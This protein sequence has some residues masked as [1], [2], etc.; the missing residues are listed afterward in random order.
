MRGG[1]RQDRR[2]LGALL[3]HE[4]TDIALV[5]IGG[6]P[7]FG[8]AALMKT[9]GVG[10]E[11][12]KVGG[13]AR[14]A[15]WNDP[16]GDPDVERYTLAEAKA[17]LTEV[18]RKLPKLRANEA[19]G[20]GARMS[21]LSA[22]PKVR[23]VLDEQKTAASTFDRAWGC[24]ALPRASRVPDWQQRPRSRWLHCGSIRSPWRTIPT[25]S[26]PSRSRRT[27]SI[28]NADWLAR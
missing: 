21:L 6:T 3:H 18:L 16:A 20:L 15:D 9:L 28:Q 14:M 1:E 13:K 24:T 7:R 12:F 22:A 11:R 5:V 10:G 27:C 4:E 26:R 8:T 25:S 2:P 19:K 23:L 17:V